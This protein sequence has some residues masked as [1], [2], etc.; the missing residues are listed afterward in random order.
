MRLII[1]ASSSSSS[2]SVSNNL[3]FK[4]EIKSA[5]YNWNEIPYKEAIKFK[6]QI[7]FDKLM[8]NPIFK[9]V[10]E[11]TL[12]YFF[13]TNESKEQLNDMVI[14]FVI[15]EN[16]GVEFPVSLVDD[17]SKKVFYDTYRSIFELFA[18]LALLKDNNLLI[19][20]VVKF[21]F[22]DIGLT[23]IAPVPANE[24]Y[25]SQITKQLFPIPIKFTSFSFIFFA[26]NGGESISFFP[27]KEQVENILESLIIYFLDNFC[28]EELKRVL[29][30]K[31]SSDIKILAKYLFIYLFIGLKN[32]KGFLTQKIEEEIFNLNLI[33][34]I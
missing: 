33:S 20:A 31:N 28:S 2:S 4:L 14:G 23:L 32:N 16:Y 12:D 6:L 26:V 17:A 27:F 3:I 34:V 29:K 15:F 30:I 9:V 22:N 11:C 8:E 7:L 10:I 1:S 21:Y 5:G 25:D 24:Y 18:I 19:K 13:L